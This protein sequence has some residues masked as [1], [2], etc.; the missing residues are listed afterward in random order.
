[1]LGTLPILVV[2]S[3]LLTKVVLPMKSLRVYFLG[4]TSITEAQADSFWTAMSK[5]RRLQAVDVGLS[6]SG[7]PEGLSMPFFLRSF[8]LMTQI[9]HLVLKDARCYLNELGRLPDNFSLLTRLTYLATI[10]EDSYR[11]DELLPSAALQPILGLPKLQ[12][13]VLATLD[14]MRQT[15]GLAL[16]STALTHL[17]FPIGVE[18]LS[19][20]RLL[21]RHMH[22]GLDMAPT[23]PMPMYG[24]PSVYHGIDL[25]ATS[26]DIRDC[27]AH[28]HDEITLLRGITSNIDVK[29]QA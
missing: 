28:M 17:S 29:L 11:G 1:M 20:V 2:C 23:S 3:L 24:A 15:M 12:T 8:A 16:Q 21:T 13:I 4:T 9:S 22:P 5:L 18:G 10:V 26:S 6:F 19:E 14:N 25:H 27:Y 7:E